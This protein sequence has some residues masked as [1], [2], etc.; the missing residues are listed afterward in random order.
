MATAKQAERTAREALMH[1]Y[2]EAWNLHDPDAVAAFFSSDAVY[3]DRGAGTV[4]RGV[5]EIRAHVASVQTGFSD[6]R[7][8]LLRAAHGED[9]NAGEW[10]ATMTHSGE[11]EGLRATGRR[12]SSAG[13]D[14]AT[15]DEKDQITHL[16][17][18]YDGAAIM[19]ELGVLPPRGSR[20]E[21]ALVRAAS[22]LPRRP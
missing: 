4:A 14:V 22:L 18:Y 12:V 2:L 9:F 21:R 16:V 3:D 6:L 19:R 17:S 11:L 20:L 13:V 7:F 1:A 15:L 5:N 8:E 10:T